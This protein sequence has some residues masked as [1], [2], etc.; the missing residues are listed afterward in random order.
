MT[1][2]HLPCRMF[3]LRRRLR[4]LCALLLAVLVVL[5]WREMN[6]GAVHEALPASMAPPI[7]AGPFAGH[8]VVER[9]LDYAGAEGTPLRFDLYAPRD[10]RATA[11]PLLIWIHGGGW[12]QGDKA[13]WPSAGYATHIAELGFVTLSIN[14]RLNS[15][16]GRAPFPAAVDDVAAFARH[17]HAGLARFGPAGYSPRISVAGHSAGGHLAL[18]LA[19]DAAAAL[20]LACVVGIAALT[21]LRADD[22]PASLRPF[23]DSFAA[24]GA[25][26]LAASPAARWRPGQVKAAS[27]FLAH[28]RDD[29]VVPFSQ[30]EALLHQARTAAPAM[31]AQALFV[32]F[33]GHE[34][35]PRQTFATLAPFLREHCA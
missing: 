32:D 19:T 15:P 18:Y 5:Y 22:F 20:P 30:S 16:F 21:D 29:A 24:D 26:R 23:I 6:Q 12:S 33:G 34:L 11:Y 7:Q 13:A 31:A 8:I 28:A 14:Y 10:Y 17:L 9:D 4:Y 3:T 27:L 2:G 1:G 35:G 25:A